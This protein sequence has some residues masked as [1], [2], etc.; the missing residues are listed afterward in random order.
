MVA[1]TGKENTHSRFRT[2]IKDTQL[3]HY[4]GHAAFD[5]ENPREHRLEFDD[6][7]LTVRDIFDLSPLPM[8]PC[9]ASGMWQWN[10]ADY[11]K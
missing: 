2:A 8:L 1:R 6:N 11:T 7:P 10:G 5:V 9:H 3:F 4:Q